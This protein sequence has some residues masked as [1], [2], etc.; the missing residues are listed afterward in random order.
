[1]NKSLL[2]LTMISASYTTIAI[3]QD[4]GYYAGLGIG[5]SSADVTEISRQ[6]VLDTGFTS[7]SG[8]QSGSSKSDTAWKI[9]GGYRLN[10]YMAAELFYANL[11]NSLVR[12]AVP[13]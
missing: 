1:M 9:F 10:P 3:A 4:Q 5:R 13:A 8:F 2:F 12:P 6:D 11:G 7:I